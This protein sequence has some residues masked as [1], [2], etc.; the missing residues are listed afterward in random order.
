MHAQ[1]WN[2]ARIESGMTL[3]VVRISFEQ[4][5]RGSRSYLTYRPLALHGQLLVVYDRH[6]YGLHRL[7]SGSLK[8]AGAVSWEEPRAYPL[9]CSRHHCQ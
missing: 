1:G 8:T 4:Y 3:H 5:V 2:L 9:H 7:Y 6:H